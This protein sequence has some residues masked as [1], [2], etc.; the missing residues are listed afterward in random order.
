M[1]ISVYPTSQQTELLAQ[2]LG[3]AIP[4]MAEM[5][6]RRENIRLPHYPPDNGK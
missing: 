2:T 1:Q 4:V 6:T 3:C 5:L